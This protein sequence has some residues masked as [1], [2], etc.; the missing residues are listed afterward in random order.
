M[1]CEKI[2]LTPG[3]GV[4]LQGFDPRALDAGN[5][6]TFRR[7]FDEHFLVLI[8]DA[9]LSETE[10]VRLTETLG[11]VSF[12]S[13]VMKQA[14]ER[15]YSFVSNTHA[16][17]KIGDGEL[18]FHSDHTFFDRPLRAIAL[19]SLEVPRQGGETVFVDAGGAYRRLPDALKA[20]IADLQGRH[21]ASYGAYEGDKR[22]VFD[23]TA[24]AKVKN[25]PVVWTHPQSGAPIL[26]VSRLITESIIGLPREESE[27]LLEELF[28]YVEDPEHAYVHRWREGDYLVWDNR[29]LQHSRRTFDPSERRALRRVPIAEPAP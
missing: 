7:A 19:S 18:L 22:P 20:R 2:R 10:Q 9:H 14:G 6:A 29:Q 8:R 28:G 15:K 25:Q 21:M 5:A 27:A 3:F 26:F 11:E 12:S 1:A 16:D 4:E 13:P 23:P 17:G 24:R